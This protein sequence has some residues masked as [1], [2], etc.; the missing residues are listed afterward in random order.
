MRQVSLGLLIFFGTFFLPT[1]KAYSQGMDVFNDLSKYQGRI[2]SYVMVSCENRSYHRPAALQVEMYIRQLDLHRRKQV[3]SKTPQHPPSTLTLS[4]F[5]HGSAQKRKEQPSRMIL[6][7]T[8]NDLGSPIGEVNGIVWQ[9]TFPVENFSWED[10]KP[11]LDKVLAGFGRAFKFQP[12][13]NK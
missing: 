1:F 8:M 9:Q 4:I 13:P 11:S 3:N 2:T 5:C 7:L 12:P 10:L 6:R